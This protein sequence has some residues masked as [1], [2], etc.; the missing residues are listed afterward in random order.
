MNRVN[1][2]NDFGGYDSSINIVLVIITIIIIII[3]TTKTTEEAHLS[4]YARRLEPG[5]RHGD[6]EPQLVEGLRAASTHVTEELVAEA[7]ED[8]L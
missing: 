7:V 8:R 1:S 5:A 3:M 4:V 6:V 2:R